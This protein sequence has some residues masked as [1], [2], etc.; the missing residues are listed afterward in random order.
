VDKKHVAEQFEFRFDRI[1][2]VLCPICGVKTGGGLCEYHREI[3]E[4]GYE[5]LREL[6]REYE[7]L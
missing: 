5:A 2:D 6:E 7:I 3:R 4:D 1:V